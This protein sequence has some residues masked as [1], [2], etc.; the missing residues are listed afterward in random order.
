VFGA[1]EVVWHY[2]P[3]PVASDSARQKRIACEVET[4]NFSPVYRFFQEPP[5]YFERL[6]TSLRIGL[7][8]H[9]S[10]PVYLRHYTVEALV[11]TEWVQFRNA[12]SAPFEPYAF[13][14]MARADPGSTAPHIGRFDLSANGFDYVMQ[15]RP[16]NL[17]EHIELWMFFISGLS[18]ESAQGISQF[19]FVFDDGAGEK[20]ACTC[21]YSVTGDRGIVMG[22]N[23]GD[24]KSMPPEPIP[25][26]IRE[27]PSH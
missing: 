6:D 26:N 25:G 15:Q 27:E 1:L 9:L 21:P 5:V 12:D 19:R 17:D 23:T 20:F 10:K 4:V 11:E 13:G 22:T 3:S 16:L 8:N 14:V 18:R 2:Q 7:T 24:L